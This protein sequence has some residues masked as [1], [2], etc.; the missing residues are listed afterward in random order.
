VRLSLPDTLAQASELAGIS[1]E[2]PLVAVSVTRL[3]LAVLHRVFGPRDRAA[4]AALWQASGF[5]KAPLNIE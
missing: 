5:P 2:S 4:W 3:L 1:H